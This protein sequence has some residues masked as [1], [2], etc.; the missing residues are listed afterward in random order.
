[1]S[2]LK[3]NQISLGPNIALGRRGCFLEEGKKPY[4]NDFYNGTPLEN[5]FKSLDLGQW[6][7]IRSFIKER[8]PDI[9]SACR[10][11]YLKDYD[12]LKNEDQEL[13]EKLKECKIL[14]ADHKLIPS[15]ESFGNLFECIVAYSLHEIQ[16]QSLR[17]AKVKYPFPNNPYDPDG[18]LYDIL[19]ALDISK[20]LWIE[21]KDNPLGQI[22]S[23]DNINKFLKRAFFLKP[24]IA[25]YLVDTKEDYKEKLRKLFSSEFLTSGNYI[26]YFEES[27][28][29]IARVN[30][31]IYFNRVNFR[32]NQLFYSGLKNSINQVLYDATKIS[33]PES[34][35]N[36]LK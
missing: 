11:S 17:E 28:N 22:I 18:Q 15:I 26:E 5:H 20:L 30:G 13:I 27:D 32:S 7:E 23:K 35:F 19:A 24:D 2:S 36:I 1:M 10:K 14:S 9:L 34:N 16:I 31:F 25:I 33:G 8:F 6:H 3:L 29:I 21:C 12:S 4:S